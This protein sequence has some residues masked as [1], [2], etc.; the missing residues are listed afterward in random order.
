MNEK[1]IERDKLLYTETYL[2]CRA[3]HRHRGK[4]VQREAEREI[5]QEKRYG[6]LV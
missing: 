5:E 1:G 4:H 6:I 2:A 3:L